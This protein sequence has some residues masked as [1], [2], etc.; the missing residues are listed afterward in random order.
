V[1]PGMVCPHNP[2]GCRGLDEMPVCCLPT[3]Q[4]NRTSSSLPSLRTLLRSLLRVLPVETDLRP[5]NR[6]SP[7][8]GAG[9]ERGVHV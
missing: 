7:F 3:N 4:T 6:I 2:D 8:P 5:P 9:C 1:L